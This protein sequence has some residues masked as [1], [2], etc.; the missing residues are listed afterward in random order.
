LVVCLVITTTL[1][2]SRIIPIILSHRRKHLG[3][4]G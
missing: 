4:K 3:V 2:I 1:C